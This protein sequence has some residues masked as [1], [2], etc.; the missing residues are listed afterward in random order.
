MNSNNGS[1]SGDC[2]IKKTRSLT[3][4]FLHMSR[5][6]TA[7]VEAWL[8]TGL[9]HRIVLPTVFLITLYTDESVSLI[10]AICSCSSYVLFAPSK[11]WMYRSCTYLFTLQFIHDTTIYSCSRQNMRLPP[12]SPPSQVY[13]VALLM[14]RTNFV[15]FWGL[16]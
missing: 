12:P 8:T 6:P 2:S 15:S 13:A 3:S 5:S 4:E 9:P 10:P 11:I 16:K 1:F 14:N 7:H